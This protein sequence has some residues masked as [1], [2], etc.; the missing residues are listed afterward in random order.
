MSATVGCDTKAAREKKN[1]I[2]N[3]V[4]HVTLLA[5]FTKGKIKH[6]LPLLFVLD[7]SNKYTFNKHFV[8]F[9]EIFLVMAE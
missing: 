4:S 2:S 1:N 9:T 7:K 8:G 6:R 3:R 5:P